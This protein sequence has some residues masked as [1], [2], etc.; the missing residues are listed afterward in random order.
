MVRKEKPETRKRS[1]RTVS[2]RLFCGAVAAVCLAEAAPA[3]GIGGED[4]AYA[5]ASAKKSSSKKT[6]SK[7]TASKKYTGW[8]TVGK[9]KY[10]YRKG[11]KTKGWKKINGKYYYF[12]RN[13]V[14]Q[15]NKIVGSK[16][17]G[18]YYV[19]QSGVRVTS[20]RIQAAVDFV[21]ANSSSRQSNEQRLKAC[22]D[23]L[24]AYPYQRI[25]G[26]K[27]SA[28]K[29]G[30]YAKYMFERRQGNCYRYASAMAYIAR[31]LGYDSRVAVG[32]VSSRS[33]GALSPH[34]WCEIKIGSTWKM[35]D[36]SM[37]QGRSYVS[38]FLVERERYPFRFQCDQ[39]F[40][41][42]SKNGKIKWL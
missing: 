2:L 23:A 9:N 29:I 10:Y 14:L 28:S 19:D 7:K 3:L 32:G 18:Y 35:C 1:A 33:Y 42:Q 12:N 27:P 25:I 16:A 26:D 30:L 41:M 5:A 38:L 24:C 17:R 11:V 40:T 31:V 20:R 8:K 6:A 4:T 13:G 21:M 37:Q 34:G 39:I 36:C 22:F 15:R